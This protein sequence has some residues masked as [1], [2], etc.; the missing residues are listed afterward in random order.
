MACEILVSRPGIESMP[1]AV[2][3]RSPNHWTTRE[4]SLECFYILGRTVVMMFFWLMI[5]SNIAFQ[6]I[7]I[8]IFDI[9]KGKQRYLP[10]FKSKLVEKIGKCFLSSFD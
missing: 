4:V 6:S 8:I 1:P 2:E 7:T 3:A 5:T 10:I 9:E